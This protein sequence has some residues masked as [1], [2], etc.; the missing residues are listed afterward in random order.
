MLSFGFDNIVS[1][2]I[3]VMFEPARPVESLV[4]SSLF[5]LIR[6]SGMSAIAL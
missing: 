4:Y 1:D 5:G 2:E 3:I 6:I